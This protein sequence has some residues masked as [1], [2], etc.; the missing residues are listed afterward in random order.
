MSDT[1]NID[2]RASLPQQRETLSP[3]VVQ[4]LIMARARLAE[5]GGDSPIINPRNEAEI[6][7][8][9]KFLAE[10]LTAHSDELIGCWVAV[11]QEYEPLVQTIERIANRVFSVRK[12][13]RQ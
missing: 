11:R 13:S 8:L 10:T 6:A 3:E 12:A 1:T 5:L 9:K 4:K 2:E 7:G